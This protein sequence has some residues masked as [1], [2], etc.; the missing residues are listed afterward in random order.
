MRGVS[1]TSE[2]KKFVMSELEKY[3]AVMKQQHNDS[4][5]K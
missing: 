1:V 5:N 3:Y 2:I 4:K